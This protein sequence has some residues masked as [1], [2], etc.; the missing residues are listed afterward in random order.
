MKEKSTGRTVM[1]ASR[2]G[3]RFAFVTFDDCGA[4]AGYQVAPLW[5]GAVEVES[6]SDD[7]EQVVRLCH[8]A[9]ESNG[10]AVGRLE[11]VELRGDYPGKK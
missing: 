9:N 7:A 4:S 10:F 3:G 11:E 2:V 8:V 6:H 1:L 5:L